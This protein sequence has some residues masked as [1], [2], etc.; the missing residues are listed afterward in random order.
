MRFLHTAILR[1]RRQLDPSM[2]EVAANLIERGHTPVLDQTGLD[3]VSRHLEFVAAR[4][5][6]R[7]CPA[8]HDER[9][10]KHQVPEE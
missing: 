8:P 3:K 2:F 4:R 7:R 6:A 1:W 10:L 5:A 9:L